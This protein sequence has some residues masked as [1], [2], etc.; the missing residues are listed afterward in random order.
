MLKN[1]MVNLARSR[2][3]LLGIVLSLMVL[4][5]CQTATNSPKIISF[6]VSPVQLPATGGDV[7]LSWQVENAKTLSID[8]GVG[9][10]SGNSITVKGVL[11]NKTFT[12]TAKNEGGQDSKSLEVKLSSAPPTSISVDPEVKPSAPKLPDERPL[13][14]L[15]NSSGLQAD[16]VQNE[17]ILLGDEAAAQNFVQRWQGQKL[18]TL[19]PP[20]KLK[21]QPIHRIRINTALAKP[22]TLNQ[23]LRRLDVGSGDAIKVSDQGGMQLLSAAMEEIAKGSKVGI[24]WLAQGQ[25]LAQGSSLEAPNRAPNSSAF[26]YNPNAATWNYMNAAGTNFGVADAWQLMALSGRLDNRIRVAVMDGGFTD[27]PD[28]DMPNWIAAVSYVPNSAARGSRNVMACGG[29]PL[30]TNNC[31]WHGTQ[32]SKMLAGIPDNNIGIAGPAGPIADLITLNVIG[33]MYTIIAAVLDAAARDT[34]II[35]MSFGIPVPI[36]LNSSVLPL[37]AVTLAARDSDDIL[38]FAAAGNDGIDVDDSAGFGAFKVETVW[39]MPCENGGVICVGGMKWGNTTKDSGSNYG[40]DEVEI[41]GPY[42]MWEGADPDNPDQSTVRIGNGTSYSS[43]FVAGIAALIWAAN[44]A[45]SADEVE[46][47]LFETANTGS[48]DA[49]VKRWP[50]AFEGVKRA[51]G[52]AEFFKDRFEVNDSGATAKDILPGRLETLSLHNN[53]DKDYYRLNFSE[54]KTRVELSLQSVKRLGKLNVPGILSSSTSCGLARL[55][56]VSASESTGQLSFEYHLAQGAHNLLVGSGSQNMYTVEMSAQSIPVKHEPDEFD[57]PRNDAWDTA[58]ML[59]LRSNYSEIPAN[60]D[61]QQDMDWYIVHSSGTLNPSLEGGKAFHFDISQSEVP[62]TVKAYRQTGGALQLYDQASSDESCNRLPSLFLPDGMYYV[63]VSSSNFKR[64]GYTF[65][66]LLHHNIRFP[67]FQKSL[68]FLKTRPTPGG[69][70]YL[71]LLGKNSGIIIKPQVG[72]KAIQILGQGFQT[73]LLDMGGNL[74]RQGKPIAQG[75]A[76]TAAINEAGGEEISFEGLSPNQ[77]YVLGVFRNDVPQDL[78]DQEAEGLPIIP[79]GI[80][81]Q[82]SNPPDTTPPVAMLEAN[83]L[84]V[85]YPQTVTIRAD[86]KDNV[87]LGAVFFYEDGQ[88]VEIDGEAPYAY[89]PTYSML[90]NGSHTYSAVMV[91]AAGNRSEALNQVTVRVEI[92]NM[93]LNPGAEEGIGSDQATPPVEAIPAFVPENGFTVVRY[94]SAGFPSEVIANDI[95]GGSNFFAGGTSSVASATQQLNI[96]D[97]ASLVDVGNLSYELSGYLGG[98][99]NQDDYAEVILTFLDYAGIELGQTRLKPVGPIERHRETTLLPRQSTGQVP[100]G[101]RAM[102]IKVVMTEASGDGYNNGYADKLRLT[103]YK[104]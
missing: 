101:T 102:Q 66:T 36:G 88:L 41:F 86:A 45:L 50:N 75:L 26:D 89:E 9:N 85:L 10:V 71:E 55:Q 21:L 104:P 32:V 93:I 73:Q 67:K 39:H 96:A 99:G 59:G 81:I 8:Q 62:I 35:N 43:P 47:I 14:S 74:L 68:K 5:A 4:G 42:T 11:A 31:P 54:E 20:A 53:S 27:Q 29:V 17:L 52:G 70:E 24:N 19:T 44:P 78:S 49:K 48:P 1:S 64:G 3:G 92:G 46:R 97:G 63:Q 90:R 100:I 69:I 13:A 51:L 61:N 28:P 94:G 2:I 77:E 22:Q 103:L 23:S 84:T 56:R 33:D 18:Q 40:E 15:K 60:F 91:D 80:G 72:V 37:N 34:R 16:F 76:R 58:S 25:S 6:S 95:G 12:L 57:I 38:L 7:T 82:S 83:N 65:G 98:Y 87:E 30:I 79:F